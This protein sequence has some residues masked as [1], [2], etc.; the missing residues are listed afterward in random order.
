M[1]SYT[2]CWDTIGTHSNDA[3]SSGPEGGG[4]R[5]IRT[6]SDP[7]QP[8]ATFRICAKVRPLMLLMSEIS[9][10][11]P[12]CASVSKQAKRPFSPPIEPLWPTR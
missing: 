1:T 12:G 6:G 10:N 4:Y 8:S 11:V 3:V 7:S 9:I 5:I 2:T